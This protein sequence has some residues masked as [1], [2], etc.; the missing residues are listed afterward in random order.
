M[1]LLN[2]IQHIEI[3]AGNS[4]DITI[5]DE[6][7]TVTGTLTDIENADNP[8]TMKLT[9]QITDGNIIHYLTFEYDKFTEGYKIYNNRNVTKQVIDIEPTPT[10]VRRGRDGRGGSRKRKT[11]RRRRRSRRY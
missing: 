9:F 3:T 5:D 4:Y 11:A 1:D 10:Q 2:K 7:L 8:K 6:L